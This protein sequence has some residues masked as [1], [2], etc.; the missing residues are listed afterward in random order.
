MELGNKEKNCILKIHQTR[1][2]D[3]NSQIKNVL[4]NERF[5]KQEVIREG[6]VKRVKENRE[7]RF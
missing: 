3:A 2:T 5:E 6:K 1:L 7:E 4:G